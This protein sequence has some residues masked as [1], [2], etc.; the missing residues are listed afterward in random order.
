M[1]L[2][3]RGFL[4]FVAGGVIGTGLTPLPWKLTDDISIWT[5][6]W[7]WIANIPDG[8]LRPAPSLV[9]L[10]QPEYGIRITTVEGRPITAAGNPDHPLSGGGI[11]PLAASSVQLLHSPARIREPMKRS[12]GGFQAISREE[13]I[14]LLTE[15]LSGLKGQRD[16]VACV[17]GDETSSAN[18]ILAGLLRDVGSERFFFHPGDTTMYHHTWQ[19]LMGGRGHIGFDL[20]GADLVLSLGPDL[21][22]SWGNAVSHQR[23]FGEN[24]FRLLYAGPV[25]N[26]TAVVAERWIPVH[27]NALGHLALA[28]IHHVLQQRPLAGK[29]LSGVDDLARYVRRNSSQIQAQKKTGLSQETIRGLARELLEAKR[30]LVIPGS[31]AGGCGASGFDLYCG[32]SL[33]LLL[34]R[35][36]TAGGLQCI[37]E[38]PK[39]VR[40]APSWSEMRQGDLLSELR[41]I[42]EGS[43]SAPEL[44]LFYESNPMY[45][46]PDKELTHKAL[47]AV[48]YKVS[49][50]QFMDE[51]AASCDLLLPHHYF[52]ER[53]DDA[54][55]PFSSPSANYS[56]AQPVVDPVHATQ[57]VPDLLLDLYRE[58]ALDPGHASYEALL[59]EKARILGADWKDLL[60]GGMWHNSTVVSQSG[61][62]LWN[63]RIRRMLDKSRD[64]TDEYQVHLVPQSNRKT[65]TPQTA[66]P[67]FGLKTLREEELE[68]DTFFVRLNRQTARKNGVGEGSLVKI[69]SPEGACRARVSLDEGVM[70]DAVVIPLGF[71]HTDW[72]EFSRG[73]GDNAQR[74]FGIRSEPGSGMAYCP[75]PRVRI[76]KIQAAR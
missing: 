23:L 30:P 69:S 60:S 61:L 51:T 41:R 76:D 8:E 48:P 72:D 46:L 28:L 2:D 75:S 74:L 39:V 49:F 57:S 50:S 44:M 59:K 66:I 27:G 42:A 34:G 15:K 52:L 13:A 68:G 6:N 62:E 40:G 73:K 54:F 26:S 70:T 58:L 21:L 14:R 71:G 67:P 5:Q 45:S 16:Q 38:P 56:V 11:D 7:P 35:L 63:D 1:A 36:N 37:P 3:R 33:N 24:G 19:K 29:N 18:E 64:G 65:G 4:K 31:L 25:Q 55:T 53:F 9:K 32:L 20:A 43:T 22:E 47:E 10:G 17:S 12:D